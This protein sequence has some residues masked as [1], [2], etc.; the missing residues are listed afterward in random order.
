MAPDLPSLE[1]CD[2]ETHN[3]IYLRRGFIWFYLPYD[4]QPTASSARWGRAEL[5]DVQ[6]SVY[7]PVVDASLRSLKYIRIIYK[8][9]DTLYFTRCAW[10][11]AVFIYI[12][13]HPYTYIFL[14]SKVHIYPRQ[15]FHSFHMHAAKSYMQQMERPNP[16]VCLYVWLL[17]NLPHFQCR[18]SYGLYMYRDMLSHVCSA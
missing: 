16:D 4:E 13:T 2:K 14:I 3:E 18:V 8:Q 12:Y 15:V 17:P 9:G 10:M 1:T 5:D 11:S 7:C 6:N